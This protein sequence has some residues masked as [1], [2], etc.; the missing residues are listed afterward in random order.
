MIQDEDNLVPCERCKKLASELNDDL[1]C[2][3]C[4]ENAG[5]RY[6]VLYGDI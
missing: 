1:I 2:Q 5:D 6:E 3:D 4:I